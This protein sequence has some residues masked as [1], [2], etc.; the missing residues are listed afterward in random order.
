MA[1]L[2]T[3]AERIAQDRKNVQ[4]RFLLI[5]GHALIYRAY[6]AFPG[7]TDGSG[8]LVNAV[9]GFARILLTSIRDFSP[10]YIA[11]CFDSKE[12]TNR[13]VEFEAYKANRPDMP[14]DLRPQIDLVKEVVTALNIPQFAVPGFEADDLIGTI[15]ES[16]RL[17]EHSG[18]AE[19]VDSPVDY[20]LVTIVTGDKDLLQLVSDHT[21]VWLPGRGKNS[22]DTEYDE[23]EVERK[24]GVKSDQIVDL[25]ALMGD[26]SDNIPG[27]AGI[28][29]KTATTLI[30]TFGSL[31]DLYKVVD[32][33]AVDRSLLDSL[34]RGVLRGSLLDKL[35]KDK[36]SAFI[37]QKLATIT[38]DAPIE[39][40]LESCRVMEYDKDRAIKL[41]ESLDFKSLIPLLPKD[42]FEI[43]VQTALF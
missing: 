15:V 7:L 31:V 32:Q 6:Y 21:H 34:G 1:E 43:G 23:A 30:Q 20:P 10:V 33:L 36:E 41:L 39:I 28:G 35:I 27:V 29:P 4:D 12:K 8:R 3:P 16:P 37:S 5:D 22:I 38:R 26:S 2:S 9:Y 11:V 13:A 19:L 24:M 42:S 17:A 40:D 25:K 14:D 18:G